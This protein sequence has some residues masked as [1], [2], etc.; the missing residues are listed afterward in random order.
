[1]EPNPENLD[2]SQLESGI[3]INGNKID[4]IQPHEEVQG[5]SINLMF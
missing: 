4:Y 5:S 2:V 3:G 1:M